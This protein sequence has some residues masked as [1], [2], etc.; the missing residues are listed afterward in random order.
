MDITTRELGALSTWIKPLAEYHL[1][2]KVKGKNKREQLMK[3]I[4]SCDSDDEEYS[5]VR[6]K[7]KVPYH[8]VWH[9]V[10]NAD[11]MAKHIENDDY[12]GLSKFVEQH[13]QVAVTKYKEE[14]K[15]QKKVAK[16]IKGVYVV[17]PIY[18]F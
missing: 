9:Y 18:P 11:F 8:A 6:G 17:I 1:K 14:L 2:Q 13:I 4:L 5:L 10:K 12:D 16:A 3:L 15:I 7:Q